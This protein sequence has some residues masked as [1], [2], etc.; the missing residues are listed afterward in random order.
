MDDLLL[1]ALLA[2]SLV[3]VIAGPLGSIMIW[4]RMVYF[5][6]AIS[7]SALLGVATGLLLGISPGW[8]ILVFC[9]LMGAGLFLLERFD[10]LASDTP[11]GIM[12]HAALA[13]GLV[14][15]SQM[16]NQRIDLM[17]YLFGDLL[18]IAEDFAL[19]EHG[20][21]QRR[22]AEVDVGDDGQGT[23]GFTCVPTHDGSSP[24]GLCV[25]DGGAL[26]AFRL[27]PRPR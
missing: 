16:D 4:R 13:A 20:I 26:R 15:V 5:G 25:R 24:P 7:H 9:L 10:W 21:H 22:L 14:V 12:A 2:G 27:E 19:P 8:T 23:D 1:Q 11:L 3:A 17:A 18:A 6:S